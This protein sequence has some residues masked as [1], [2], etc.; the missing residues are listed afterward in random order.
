MQEDNTNKLIEDIAKGDTKAFHE[1]Y[2]TYYVPLCKF[3]Y[4]FLT[5]SSLA[6]DIVQD[7]LLK[8]WD[9]RSRMFEITNLKSY[10]FLSV[11]NACFNHWEHQK[12]IAKHADAVVAEINLTS[13]QDENMAFEDEAPNLEELVMQAIEQLPKQ[14]GEVFKLKYLEGKRTK[15]IAEMTNLSPRTVETHVYNALKN[16]RAVFKDFDP[17]LLLTIGMF[18]QFYLK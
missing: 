8:F 5:D 14:S 6:E 11:K 4:K 10:L 7:T 1:I 18:F 15:E 3:A 9:Q 17:F 13:L 16:L 2:R 12:V